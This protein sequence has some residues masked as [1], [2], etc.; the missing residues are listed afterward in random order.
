MTLDAEIAPV[1]FRKLKSTASQID[2]AQEVEVSQA[3]GVQCREILIKLGTMII[4]WNT[5]TI[6]LA[7]MEW[8]CLTAIAGR[9]HSL[10]RKPIAR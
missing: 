5:A 6:F 4:C 1:L 10:F 8:P 3:I 9:V 7:S 2:D